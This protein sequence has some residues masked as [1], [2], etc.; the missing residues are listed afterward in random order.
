MIDPEF[1]RRVA[2]IVEQVSNLEMDPNLY[3]GALLYLCAWYDLTQRTPP[4]PDP[5]LVAARAEIRALTARV[6]K[7]EQ[8]TEPEYWLDYKRRG[9]PRRYGTA[10]ERAAYKAGYNAGRTRRQY[11]ERQARKSDAPSSSHPAAGGK[12]GR[13]EGASVPESPP[14]PAVPAPLSSAPPRPRPTPRPRRSRHACRIRG[15]ADPPCRRR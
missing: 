12:A 14:D 8:M 10:E 2:R 4:A 13:S 11:R 7:L 9:R 3:A 6:R 5:A 15:C 1:E